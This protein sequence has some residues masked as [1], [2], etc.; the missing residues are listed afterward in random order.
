MRNNNYLSLINFK[1]KTSSY[2][3]IDI[4]P[5]STLTQI[6][7]TCLSLIYGLNKNIETI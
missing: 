2:P 4:S 7:S 3:F 1:I 6:G 5:M